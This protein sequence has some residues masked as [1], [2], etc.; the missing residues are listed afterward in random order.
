M[1]PGAS[2][3]LALGGPRTPGGLLLSRDGGHTFRELTRQDPRDPDAHHFYSVCALDEQHAWAC[4]AAGEDDTA[5]VWRTADG[6]AFWEVLMAGDRARGLAAGAMY[7]QV[8]F[9]DAQHGFLVCAGDDMLATRDGGRSWAPLPIAGA[10]PFGVFFLDRWRGWALSHDLDGR[11]VALCT[12]VFATRDGGRTW[13]PEAHDFAGLPS[14]DVT[15]FRVDRDGTATLCGPDGMLLW[16]RIDD[17][18]RAVRWRFARG[19]VAG[20]LNFVTR[21]PDGALWVAGE[22][23]VLLVSRDGGA[24]YAEVATGT[25]CDLHALAFVPDGSSVAGSAVGDR[26]TM[27]R[28]DPRAPDAPQRTAAPWP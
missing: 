1:T 11:G 6:G 7:T 9:T 2:L 20:D 4:G 25:R 22:R 10:Q 15:G 18:A 3:W 14:L 26:G 19:T 16:A 28:F 23:G 21:S 13:R 24:S 12:R 17:D 5:V 8:L 27:L